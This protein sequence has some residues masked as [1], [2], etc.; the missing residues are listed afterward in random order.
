VVSIAGQHLS[1]STR[2]VRLAAAF[3]AGA[4]LGYGIYRA[5]RSTLLIGVPVVVVGSSV[6]ALRYGAAVNS[7]LPLAVGTYQG[8]VWRI[9]YVAERRASA[10][11]PPTADQQ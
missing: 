7:K 8:S 5:P 2:A 3:S 6:M 1:R 11:P 4:L 10:V 9:P